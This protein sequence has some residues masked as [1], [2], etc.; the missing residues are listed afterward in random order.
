MYVDALPKCILALNAFGV[1][2]FGIHFPKENVQ[3]Q[4]K[5]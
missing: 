2:H 4:A 1:L 5:T 3:Q